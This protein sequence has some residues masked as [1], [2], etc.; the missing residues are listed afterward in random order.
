M[1]SFI[2]ASILAFVAA[3]AA[4]PSTSTSTLRFAKRTSPNG[5]G[6]DPGQQGVIN[7]INQWNSDVQTV[8][9]FLEVAP[10]LDPASLDE[11]IEGA[12]TAAQDEPN[13]LQVLACESDVDPGT[14]AQAAVDDLFNGF[15]NNVLTPL[16]NILA[17]S[18]DAGVVASNLQT[19]NQFRCCNVLPDLDTLWTATAVD[20]GV[21]NV[22][23]LSAPRPSTC[24]SI[25]C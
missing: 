18:G 12:L 10:S 8:N 17:N 3:S 4:A 7:A 14:A 15:E 6:G 16:G 19:I 23:P 9:S 22:V 11:Q 24:A 13:Q 20:E 25:T 2:A 21:A 5:C 1:K